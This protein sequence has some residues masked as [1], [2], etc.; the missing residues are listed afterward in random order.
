MAY[1]IQGLYDN[2][3]NEN[4]IK[5]ME[6]NDDNE[7]KDFSMRIAIKY[8]ILFTKLSNN[9]LISPFIR[10]KIEKDSSSDL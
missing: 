4:L 10:G 5:F 6:S 7:I 1:I 8:N 2:H 3:L 9:D